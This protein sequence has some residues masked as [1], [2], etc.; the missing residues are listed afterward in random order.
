MAIQSLAAVAALAT[1]AFLFLAAGSDDRSQIL[2]RARQRR[3]AFDLDRAVPIPGE[4]EDSTPFPEPEGLPR[5]RGRALDLLEGLVAI[6]KELA[7]EAAGFDRRLRRGDYGKLDEPADRAHRFLTAWSGLRERLA[8]E[9]VALARRFGRE[10]DR[11]VSVDFPQSA[12]VALDL[13]DRISLGLG[14][15]LLAGES[16]PFSRER[17]DFTLAIEDLRIVAEGL[18]E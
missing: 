14:A 10:P 13:L 12:V 11:I 18:P 17:A 5:T 2:D 6:E 4:V 7:R 3:E 9:L 15:A 16:R 1:A 8:G